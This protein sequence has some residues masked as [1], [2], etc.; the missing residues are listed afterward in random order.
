MYKREQAMYRAISPLD[1][2]SACVAQPAS[3]CCSL[4]TVFVSS[5][6]RWSRH[7]H[8]WPW[9]PLPR[10]LTPCPIH[11]LSPRSPLGRDAG[12]LLCALNAAVARLPVTGMCPVPNAY[13]QSRTAHSIIRTTRT[14]MGN[15]PAPSPTSRS[16]CTRPPLVRRLMPP[17]RA[18]SCRWCP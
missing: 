5:T 4:I 14:P 9:P 7:K 12:R 10:T 13:N 17:K 3:L 1:K 11:V 2:S 6:V 15:K 18:P 8:T 16:L